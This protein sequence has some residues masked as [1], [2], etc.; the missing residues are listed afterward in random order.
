[1]RSKCVTCIYLQ[2]NLCLESWLLC[3]NLVFFSQNPAEQVN[4]VIARKKDNIYKH[5]RRPEEG[6]ECLKPCLIFYTIISTDLFIYIT[7]PRKPCLKTYIHVFQSQ[8]WLSGLITTNV[9][10]KD[11]YL[12]MLT[13]RLCHFW[14]SSGLHKKTYKNTCPLTS[15][16]LVILPVTLQLLYL[17]VSLQFPVQGKYENSSLF[18]VS[19]SH[20]P[21]APGF[22][23]WLANLSTQQRKKAPFEFDSLKENFK[24]Q[25][26]KDPMKK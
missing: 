8:S 14:F 26:L 16:E 11:C 17:M 10:A 1:M 4:I 24:L 19:L 25:G 2:R 12:V 18:G 22:R 23:Q 9:L 13:I 15:A 20:I 5:I 6:L 3:S 21:A 7:P